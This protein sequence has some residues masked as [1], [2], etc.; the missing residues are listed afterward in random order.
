MLLSLAASHHDLDLD[1]L[2]RLSTDVQAVASELVHS[3][4]SVSGAVVLATCNRFE[5]YLEVDDA[6]DTAVARSAAAATVAERSGYSTEQ[7]ASHLR[8]L[9]G[10]DAASHLFAVASGLESMVVGEREIAGQVRRAALSGRSVGQL[11]LSRSVTPSGSAFKQ[12]NRTVQS[13]GSERRVIGAASVGLDEA[14]AQR[15][16]PAMD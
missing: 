3:A 5:L 13:G 1:V 11:E 10:T 12:F 15:A 14:S 16:H 9:T 7:V 4:A 8:V 6:Q 2:E